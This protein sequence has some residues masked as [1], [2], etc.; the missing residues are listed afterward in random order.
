MYKLKD[1]VLKTGQAAEQCVLGILRY[2][3][4]HYK[5]SLAIITATPPNSLKDADIMLALPNGIELPFCECKL[6]RYAHTTARVFVETSNSGV[7]SCLA[8]SLATYWAFV[9]KDK[10]YF[11][12]RSLLRKTSRKRKLIKTRVNTSGFFLPCDWLQENA[13]HI[14]RTPKSFVKNIEWRQ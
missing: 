3:F 5:D 2:L 8:V 1:N 13:L 6:D 7:P 14:W 9:T 12:R 4:P 10:T 11:V